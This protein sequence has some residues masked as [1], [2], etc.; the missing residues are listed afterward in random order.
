MLGLVKAFYPHF[1]IRMQVYLLDNWLE[2]LI[3][4]KDNQP[5]SG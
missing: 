4:V 5:G 2:M 3:T 1:P